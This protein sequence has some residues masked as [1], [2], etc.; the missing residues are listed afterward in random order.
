M[1]KFLMFFVSALWLS[2]GMP[3]LA[4]E[5][6]PAE[7]DSSAEILVN[8][9]LK[10]GI[11]TQQEAADVLGEMEEI[12]AKAEA[13][14]KKIPEKGTVVSGK[15]GKKHVITGYT[16]ADARFG[17]SVLR[18]PN[19]SAEIRRARIGL[20]GTIIDPVEYKI[21]VDAVG[22]SNNGILRDAKLSYKIMDELVLNAGQYKA[23]FGREELTSSSRIDTVERSAFSNAITP[24]R[25]VGGTLS[26][27]LFHEFLT[28]EAGAFNGNG[29]NLTNDDDSFL[30]VGRVVLTPYKT[31]DLFGKEAKLELAGNLGSSEDTNVAL[32]NLGFN[33]FVGDRDLFGFDGMVEWG[34]ASLKGEYLRAELDFDGI[35]GVAANPVRFTPAVAAIPARDVDADGFS[36]IGSYF[37]VPKRFQLVSKWEEFDLDGAEEFEALTLGANYYLAEWDG[38]SYPT[39]FMVNYVHGDQKGNDEEDQVLMRLQVGY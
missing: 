23:P 19:N 6:A 26:G 15:Y 39:R 35:P 12:Q 37:L 16:Q 2:W 3:V 10:K 1:K 36:I 7:A 33:R 38:K 8:L 25:Q 18:A 20:E 28:Y 13:K 27:K 30:Y 22:I 11:L 9:L 34:P 21:L 17:D 31:D 24:D 5:Q 14:V 4:K 32:R 29:Q